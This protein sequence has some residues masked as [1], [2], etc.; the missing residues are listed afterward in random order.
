[1]LLILQRSI[2]IHRLAKTFLKIHGN[3][4]QLQTEHDDKVKIFLKSTLWMK[5]FSEGCQ[6]PIAAPVCVT[7]HAL[8]PCSSNDFIVIQKIFYGS[9]AFH[10]DNLLPLVVRE[11]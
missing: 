9:N 1:M 10:T 6:S 5:Q 7:R 11:V 4:K 3:Q 8:V 2:Y